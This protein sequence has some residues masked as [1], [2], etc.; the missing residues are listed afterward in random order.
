MICAPSIGPKN[1]SVPLLINIAKTHPNAV[2][3]KQAIFWLGQTG[4]E[5]A[6]EFFKE[7]LL[8]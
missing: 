2:V 3:R 1:E 8:K 7:L 6:V 5:R 4:D